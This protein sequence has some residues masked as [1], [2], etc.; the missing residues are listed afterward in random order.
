MGLTKSEIFTDEQNQLSTL[1]KA[2]AHPARIAIL[3]QIISANACICSDL[4]EELGLAQATISQHLKELKNAG[5]IQGTIEGVTVCY[6]IN[7]KTWKLLE[8]QLGTF[9][10]SYKGETPCC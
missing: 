7:P 1:L 9:L 10:G 5:I 8:T 4:V 3:Q 2:M 6:C